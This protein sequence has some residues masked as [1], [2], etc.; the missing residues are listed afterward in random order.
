MAKRGLRKQANKVAEAAKEVSP[1]SPNP[2]TNVVLADI[3]LRTGGQL[4]RHA[5]ER[6]VLGM[7]YDKKKARDIVKGRSMTQA[8]VGTA[9]ARLATRSVPGALLVGGGMLAKA[10]FDRRKSR[11]EA[12][13]EGEAAVEE[14][15]ERAKSA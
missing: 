12:R 2:M 13:A 15:A 4:M 5:I 3:A 7:K 8:L 14:Q 10:L 1:P 6:S 9:I 11:T